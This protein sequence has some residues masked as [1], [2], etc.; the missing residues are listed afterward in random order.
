MT[1]RPGRVLAVSTAGVAAVWLWSTLATI[2]AFA[3]RY[4]AFDQYRLY[5]IY[6]GLPFPSSALQLENGHRPILPALLRIAEIHALAADQSLQIVVGLAA[7]VASLALIVFTIVRE[8]DMEPA[9]RGAAILL[10]VLAIFWLGNARVLMHGNESVQMYFV[11]LFVVLAIL[12]VDKART[13]P[14][15]AWIVGAG[16]CCLAASFSF[17]TGMA[18]FAAVFVL[19]AIARMGAR[20]MAIPILLFVAA[21]SVYALGLPGSAGVRHVLLVRPLANLASML[22]WLSAPWMS[23]WLGNGDAM[24]PTWG[25]SAASNE[26][27]GRAV[28]ASARWI[29]APFGDDA[30]MRESLLVGALG[31]IAFVAVSWHAWRRGRALSST[32]FLALGLSAF[33][34]A[35]GVLVCVARL[36]AFGMF[37]ADVF[38]DRYLPWSCLFWFGL[39]LYAC[40]GARASKATVASALAVASLAAAAILLTSQRSQAGW[41]ATVF[42][43]VQQ[44]AAAAELGVWD[45]EVLPDDRSARRDVVIGSLALLREHRLSM[46]AEPEFELIQS[47]W[48]LA[49]TLPPAQAG[50]EAHVNRTLH[51][52]WGQRDVASFE[53]LL[54]KKPETP[55]DALLVV[56]DSSGALRGLAKRSFVSF[57]G[58]SLRFDRPNLRGFDGYVLDPKPGEELTVLVLDRST[59]A[60]LAAIPLRIPVAAAP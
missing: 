26:G 32:R 39:A 21:L 54:A 6:L 5:A 45:P 33:A 27:L 9:A 31:G 28:L 38:A 36:Q 3:F 34:L 49:G 20:R 29:A 44:S 4:P 14:S 53:G 16:A 43:H 58:K 22:R 35:A 46:Y 55:R 13:Q 50:S 52:T 48:R 18:S 59:Q 60:P 12:A 56:V 1:A 40:A 17:G 30:L 41:S 24:L 25:T 11:V 7:A 37:P 57:S 2:A 10:A 8:R 42:R 47:G 23:A 51:D 15:A 19:G